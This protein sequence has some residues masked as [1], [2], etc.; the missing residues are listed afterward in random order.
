M[1]RH[2]RTLARDLRSDAASAL[3]AGSSLALAAM[4]FFAVFREGFETAV[5]LLAAFQA[6]GNTGMA[7]T[8]AVTGVL[9]AV[10]IGWLVYCGGV[11]LDLARFFRVTGIVLV[12]VAAGLVASALHT[13]HEA[14]WLD[15]GQA[16]AL[17]LSWLVRP[18]TWHSS[19][20]TGML[21]LQPRPTVAELVGWLAYAVPM[22][23]FVAWPRPRLPALAGTTTAAARA[24]S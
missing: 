4:A 21:G 10:V 13:A 22:L 15:A 14:A 3:A 23:L 7:A 9:A 1:R 11:R 5:F 17:D 2:G 18:G 6:S 24:S 8:G 20:L 19:L 12:L 16:Q